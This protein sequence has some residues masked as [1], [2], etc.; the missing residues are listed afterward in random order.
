MSACQTKYEIPLEAPYLTPTLNGERVALRVSVED[1]AKLERRGPGDYGS[2]VD[3]DTGKRYSVRGAACEV[4]T[5]YCDA[6]IVEVA[7]G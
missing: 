4:P 5:C 1:S 3:L 7:T 2:I 6:A